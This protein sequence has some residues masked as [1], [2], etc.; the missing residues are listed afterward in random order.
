[1]FLLFYSLLK[2][3]LKSIRKSLFLTFVSIRGDRI[4]IYDMR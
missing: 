2:E 4:F 3:L 1:M